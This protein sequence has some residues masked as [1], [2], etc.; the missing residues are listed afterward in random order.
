MSFW[1]AK[2]GRTPP[3]EF[4]NQ[5]LFRLGN[6][7][8]ADLV[9]IANAISHIHPADGFLRKTYELLRPGGEVVVVD[10]NGLFL[11]KQIALL[12]ERGLT[13]YTT[14]KDP[15]TG[16]PVPY[17]V[18]RIYSVPAICRLLRRAGFA[19]SHREC[20]TG[21]TRIS[22]DAVYDNLI[23]P[24]NRAPVLSAVLGQRYVVAGIK[25]GGKSAPE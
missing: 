18:E 16:E 15:E 23:A 2:L 5:N 11:P 19:I 8:V 25:S 3:V 10:P 6:K 7:E 13:R 21:S 4:S 9:W 12:F 1:E 20:F 22:N 24:L 14:K 17:A